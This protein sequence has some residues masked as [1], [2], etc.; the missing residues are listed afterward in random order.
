L[1]TSAT[2]LPISN[3]QAYGNK[4]YPHLEAFSL[5][6]DPRNEYGKLYTV[7]KLG[8]VWNGIPIRCAYPL[9]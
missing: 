7:S 4:Q 5:I 8:N 9:T 3:T 1:N 2:H 6:N